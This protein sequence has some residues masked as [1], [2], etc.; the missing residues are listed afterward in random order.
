[1]TRQF[2][3]RHRHRKR[4]GLYTLQCPGEIQGRDIGG[5]FLVVDTL[6]TVEETLDA[7]HHNLVVVQLLGRWSPA[8]VRLSP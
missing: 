3:G 7:A 5:K 8:P 2:P 4:D 6:G 1:M